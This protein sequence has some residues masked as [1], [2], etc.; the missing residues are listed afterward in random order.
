MGEN[1]TLL[2]LV[3]AALAFDKEEKLLRIL[4]EY[5]TTFRWLIVDIKGINPLIYMHKILIKD[6]YEPL[7]KYQRIL[8]TNMKQVV[9]KEENKRLDAGIIYLIFY[10]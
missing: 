1:L 3:F 2:V 8:N 4:R 9:R 10:S 5:K 6:N 7:V